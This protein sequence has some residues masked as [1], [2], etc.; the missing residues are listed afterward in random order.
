MTV[1]IRPAQQEL[2]RL[3]VA[4]TNVPHAPLRPA[5]ARAIPRSLRRSRARPPSRNSKHSFTRGSRKCDREGE[6]LSAGFPLLP[7]ARAPAAPACCS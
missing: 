2:L 5:A 6:F 7:A 4:T 3:Q 1:F